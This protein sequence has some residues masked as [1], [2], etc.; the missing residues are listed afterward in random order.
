M[1]KGV[2]IFYLQN[3]KET[4]AP[5]WYYKEAKTSQITDFFQQDV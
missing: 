2:S 5:L 3:K 4:A 1:G